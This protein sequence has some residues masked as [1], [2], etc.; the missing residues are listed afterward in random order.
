MDARTFHDDPGAAFRLARS[1]ECVVV[2]NDVGETV[3]V[4]SSQHRALPK[5]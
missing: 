4:I 2:K 1:H 3:V 5:R